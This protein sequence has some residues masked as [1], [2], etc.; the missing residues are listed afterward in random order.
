MIRSYAAGFI[1]TTSLPPTVVSGA[2]S[3]VTILSGPEGRALRAKHQKAVSYLRSLLIEKGLPVEH[4]PSHIIPIH[5]STYFHVHSEMTSVKN[6]RV[7]YSVTN[8]RRN[9]R[10][11]SVIM[12]K[13]ASNLTNFHVVHRWGILYSVL[14]SLMN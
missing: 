2:L 13:F 6:V 7:L 10:F 5:V 12:F 8:F 14:R 9:C 11:Q 4:C 1:F 3:A